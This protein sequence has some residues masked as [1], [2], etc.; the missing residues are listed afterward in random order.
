MNRSVKWRPSKAALAFF[1]FRDECQARKVMIPSGAR[2]TFY[3]EMPESWSRSKREKMDLSPHQQRP[4]LDN[5]CKAILDAIF[6]EDCVIYDLRLVKR[7]SN[8]GM[9]EVAYFGHE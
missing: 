7:W 6:E 3:I 9:I 8:I 4:D 1:A 2:I 5:Y